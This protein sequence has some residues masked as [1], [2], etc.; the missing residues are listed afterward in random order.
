M[1]AAVPRIY[2][3]ML[4]QQWYSHEVQNELFAAGIK[5]PVYKDDLIKVM[6]DLDGVAP[7]AIRLPGS[8]DMVYVPHFGD[9]SLDII[10]DTKRGNPLAEFDQSKMCIL[11][12]P[13]ILGLDYAKFKHGIPVLGDDICDDP[14]IAEEL[15]TAVDGYLPYGFR[16]SALHA[17]DASLHT[18]ERALNYAHKF[19]IVGAKLSPLS[20][21][22][23]NI[24][25]F[26][27]FDKDCP[28]DSQMYIPI[29]G[30]NMKIRVI[31]KPIIVNNTSVPMK[32]VEIVA[33]VANVDDRLFDFAYTFAN[34]IITHDLKITLK[35]VRIDKAN[36]NL[37]IVGHSRGEINMNTW[38]HKMITRKL[39]HGLFPYVVKSVN[40]NVFDGLP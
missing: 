8:S 26:I 16:E 35:H 20:S 23:A 36:K 34:N 29:R 10:H 5:M 21:G 6:S 30:S 32:N 33:N 13:P 19:E 2:E 27:K 18:F 7:E 37:I 25:M 14:E 22:K 9:K 39:T 17:Q 31:P 28:F 40:V 3:C 24:A 15:V 1:A 38:V 12:T 4:P 11:I